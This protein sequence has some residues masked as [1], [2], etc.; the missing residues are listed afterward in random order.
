MRGPVTDTIKFIDLRAAHEE[1]GAELNAAVSRV[2][3]S[4]WYLLGPELES[5]ES[6]FAE[7]CGT[8]HCV[9]VASGLSA[10]ELALQ[11][12]GIG[13]GDEVIVPAYTWV[14]TWIAVTKTGARP[15]PVDVEE[16]TYNIDPRQIPAAITSSTAAIVPVHL[17]GQP[18]DMD[19]ISEIAEAHRLAVIEDAAQAHGARHR[20]RRAGSLATAAAFSF[21]PTKN[22]GALGDGGAVTTDDDEIADRVRLLRNYGTRDRYSIETAG[23]NSRLAEI[24]AAVLRVK[25]PRLDDWNAA[26]ARLAEIYR[27]A[28]ADHDSLSV[29]EVPDW[30]DPVWHLF[31]VGHPDRNACRAALE[32]QG[33]ETLVHYPVPPHLSGAYG[34]FGMGRGSFPVTECL[35]DA[36]LSLPIYPQLAPKAC[37][38]VA[39]AVVQ[40]L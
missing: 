11:A 5:F 35:A 3:D 10:L 16:H 40:T 18:A 19:A 32:E 12:A 9:G 33:I 29:P 6:E 30:A 22:L 4:G 24:Q 2:V 39:A 25:L 37:A 34:D 36:T 1:I 20:G 15:V 17:R 8:R 38:E 14:A 23:V 27:L 26:R 7:Y 13:P 31:V 28:F 21:Y